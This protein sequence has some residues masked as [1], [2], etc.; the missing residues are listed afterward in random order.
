LARRMLG[1]TTRL[2]SSVSTAFWA[3]RMPNFLA[4]SRTMITMVDS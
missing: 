4:G 3:A 2:S 1:V